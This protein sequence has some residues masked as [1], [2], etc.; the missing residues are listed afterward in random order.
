MPQ[1]RDVLYPIF[2][3]AGKKGSKIDWQ[4]ADI[5]G[6]MVFTVYHNIILKARAEAHFGTQLS[7]TL[8]VFA[9]WLMG[10][11]SASSNSNLVDLFMWYM[12][13]QWEQ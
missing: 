7:G 6:P 10:M 3:K 11:S 13:T 4:Y 12:E 9:D 5:I 2:M 8:A 1:I